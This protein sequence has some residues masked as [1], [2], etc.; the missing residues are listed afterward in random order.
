MNLNK[1]RRKKVTEIINL[2]DQ[3]RDILDKIIDEENK[4]YE[5]LPENFR[6]SD[7][8][9]EIYNN[10]DDMCEAYSGL[11]LAKKSLSSM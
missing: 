10:V 2:V 6:Y 9:D 11:L 3:A 4:A 7:R 8:G 5:N 1:S